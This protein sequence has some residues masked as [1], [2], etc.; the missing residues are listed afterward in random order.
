MLIKIR[1]FLVYLIT[2]LVLSCLTISHPMYSQKKSNESNF[3]YFMNKGEEYFKHGDYFRA[4]NCFAFCV[5]MHHPNIAIALKRKEIAITLFLIKTTAD[6]KQK[7]GDEYEASKLYRQILETNPDD[8]VAKSVIKIR[9][10]QKTTTPPVV[11]A[12]VKTTTQPSS[13]SST[14]KKALIIEIEKPKEVS[15]TTLDLCKAKSDSLLKIANNQYGKD[16][17]RSASKNYKEAKKL[18]CNLNS[19]WIDD[20]IYYCKRTIDLVEDI[21]DSEK[22][23]DESSVKRV[24][25]NYD[26]LTR[27]FAPKSVNFKNDYY[28]YIKIRFDRNPCNIRNTFYPSKMKSLNEKRFN[29]DNIEQILTECLKIDT[30]NGIVA[31]QNVK[32]KNC[33]TESYQIS[34]MKEEI[35]ES[36]RNIEEG[37]Y[38]QAKKRLDE[39]QKKLKIVISCMSPKDSTELPIKIQDLLNDISV[40]EKISECTFKAKKSLSQSDSLYSNGNCYKS[41]SILNSITSSCL[42]KVDSNFYSTLYSRVKCCINDSLYVQY[43]NA[44]R[45]MYL[46]SAKLDYEIRNGN[47]VCSFLKKAISFTC[48]LADSVDLEK[49]YQECRCKNFKENCPQPIIPIAVID[50]ISSDCPD[51]LTKFK[52]R[53]QPF[54]LGASYKYISYESGDSYETNIS[55][56][57]GFGANINFMS[58]KK[59]ADFRM[60]FSIENAQ[61]II[62]DTKLTFPPTGDNMKI[63][64]GNLE[65]K[66]HTLPKCPSNNRYY[67]SPGIQF[68]SFTANAKTVKLIDYTNNT[69]NDKIMGG[70][71]VSIGFEK[72]GSGSK[73]GYFI[74]L[75]YKQAG[76]VYSKE[77]NSFQNIFESKG[78]L[79]TIGFKVGLLLF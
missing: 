49:Q 31:K 18:G 43:M 3:D 22:N 4:K 72:A 20:A 34:S 1:F 32:V 40:K 70:Y 19:R 76:T 78:T 24:L 54:L 50:T 71:T 44:N 75:Y 69:F 13:N 56:S 10:S 8:D 23:N 26:L 79:Q 65:I 74:E 9:E 16:R 39:A 7:E 59:I 11:V 25:N 55:N 30:S 42:S 58:Y 51:K 61:Y 77:Q 29:K 46:D 47:D 35:K 62:S 33:E 36:K 67:I 38:S 5:K 2:I 57:I 52:I 66:L 48:S 14:T 28:D 73:I 45:R 63:L 6:R 12:I 60:G 37:Q 53:L 68:H 17:F 27:K 41:Y 64:S 21:S 15:V